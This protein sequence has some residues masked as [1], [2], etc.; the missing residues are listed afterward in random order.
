MSRAKSR[1]Y[2]SYPAAAALGGEVVLIPPLELGA[3]RQWRLA[4]CLAAD[5]VAADGDK[6]RA[7]LGPCRGDDVGRARTPVETSNGRLLD[8]ERVEQRDGIEGQG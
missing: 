8:L 2:G 7:A 6:A 1:R 5:Q 4:G 3:R